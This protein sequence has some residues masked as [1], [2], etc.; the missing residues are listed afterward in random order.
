MTEEDAPLP[1]SRARSAL[2]ALLVLAWA[3]PTAVYVLFVLFAPR[4]VLTQV[5][6]LSSLCDYLDASASARLTPIDLFAHARA[7]T[8]PQ[9]ARGATA[10]AMLLWPVS[11]V[12]T[13]F[14]ALVVQTRLR[15]RLA[16]LYSFKHGLGLAFLMPVC[17]MF[18]PAFFALHGDPSF[19]KGLTTDGRVGFLVM[20]FLSLGM[21]AVLAGAWPIF[22]L[23][24]G[25]MPFKQPSA[26][27]PTQHVI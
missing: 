1:P 27:T 16:K 12:G 17:A 13:F 3:I 4:D 8:F 10:V 6:S 7:T 18:G 19:A 26:S 21:S 2:R 5:R 9:V 15:Q 22:V 20:S 14:A 11:V 25:K 23:A 24:L